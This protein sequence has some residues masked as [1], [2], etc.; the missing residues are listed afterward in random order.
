MSKLHLHMIN[1]I[2]FW[3]GR[4]CVCVCVCACVCV[5]VRVCACV[6]VLPA[7]VELRV[8]SLSFGLALVALLGGLDGS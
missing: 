7:N 8:S 6:C 4:V 3:C 1:K 5:C 2:A